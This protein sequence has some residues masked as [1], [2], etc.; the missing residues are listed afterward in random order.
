MTFPN[1][2]GNLKTSDYLF[3]KVLKKTGG[4]I[5]RLAMVEPQV[6]RK[7]STLETKIHPHP[8][9]REMKKTIAFYMCAM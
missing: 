6:H 9:Q 2:S 7:R 4:R 5:N 1:V 3:L 8:S